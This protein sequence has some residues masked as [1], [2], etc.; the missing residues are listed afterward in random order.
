MDLFSHHNI[1]EA[2]KRSE[3]INIR[4]EMYIPLHILWKNLNDLKISKKNFSDYLYLIGAKQDMEYINAIIPILYPEDGS[5][6]NIDKSETFK[7]TS[8]LR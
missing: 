4:G 5:I 3:R 8:G 7:I 2:L 1:R 6:P